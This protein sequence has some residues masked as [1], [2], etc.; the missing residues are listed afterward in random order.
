LEW[1]VG[2]LLRRQVGEGLGGFADCGPA[3]GPLVDDG[4]G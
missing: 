3:R 2:R 4:R 1:V